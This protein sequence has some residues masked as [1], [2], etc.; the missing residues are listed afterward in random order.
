MR[1]VHIVGDCRAARGARIL[2]ARDVT[3]MTAVVP[4]RADVT[5]EIVE[6]D[7]DV[8]QFDGVDTELEW[9]VL[10]H[11]QRVTTGA[12]VIPR[13]NPARS[14]R[15]DVLRI[16]VPA[17]NDAEAHA[18]ETAVYRALLDA[19]TE[20]TCGA[21]GHTQRPRR[22]R[23]WHVFAVVVVL[24]AASAHAQDREPLPTRPLIGPLS[25]VQDQLRAT[26]VQLAIGESGLIEKDVTIAALQAT[27][28]EQRR[29]LAE[30]Q[31]TSRITAH[32]DRLKTVTGVPYRWDDDTKHFV[33]VLPALSKE[34]RP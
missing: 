29:A 21:C 8:T 13:T 1:R 9:R 31:L 18:V 32:L 16:T 26:E 5:I 7:T 20:T 12:I 24:G 14:P 10:D 15:E 33:P 28:A 34:S 23:W 2:I 30:L 3:L 11:L 27:V 22:R 19:A 17:G 25:V 4:A 6:A